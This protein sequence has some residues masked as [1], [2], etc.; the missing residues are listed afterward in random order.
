MKKTP[1]QLILAIA[2]SVIV[3][4]VAVAMIF[5]GTDIV[6]E[7]KALLQ[8]DNTNVTNTVETDDKISDLTTG[9]Y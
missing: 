2:I 3:A 5:E 9:I 4:G 7:I 8:K 1:L 6:S